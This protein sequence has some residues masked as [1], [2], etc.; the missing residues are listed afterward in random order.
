MN[1]ARG[2]APLFAGALIAL[3]PTPRAG[4]ARRAALLL[5]L[6]VGLA[7]WRLLAP[8]GRGRRSAT[9]PRPPAEWTGRCVGVS[10]GDTVRVLWERT[11]VRVRL[12]GVD[13]PERGQAF[14][15]AARQFTARAV[16]GA[17]VTVRRRSTDRYG[18]TVAEVRSADGTSLGEALVAS[19]LA[20]W[21]RRYAPKDRRLQALEREARKERRG[22]WAD[23]HAQAPWEYRR[24]ARE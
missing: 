8:D 16:F 3:R 11:E 13:C 6:L 24:R 21:Y 9:A 17:E 23:P 4:K 1:A 10:D 14:A 18:R 12:H 7:A 15:A 20:W 2:E 19:G 5:L 22:L